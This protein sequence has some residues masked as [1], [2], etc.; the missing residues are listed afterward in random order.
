MLSK[1]PT[2][3]RAAII[4][5]LQTLAGAVLLIILNLLVDIQSWVSDRS[6]PVDFSTPAA[7]AGAALLA[8]VVGV[9]TAVYRGLRPVENT[10]PEPPHPP[11]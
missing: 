11:A 8:F 6:N 2:W 5:G 10:Y 4:T 1:L 7:L 9:V 3:L